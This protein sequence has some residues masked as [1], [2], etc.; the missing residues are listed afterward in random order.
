MSAPSARR[1]HDELLV[2]LGR[3][4]RAEHSAVT[5]F[6]R[7]WREDLF[8]PLGHATIE[9][10]GTEGL[11]L[12]VAKTR[13][14]LRL[15]RALDELPATREALDA[16]HLD[17]TK[18]RT[19]TAVATPRTEARWVA[20]AAAATSRELEAKVRDARLRN[21]RERERQRRLRGQ[22]SMAL[23]AAATVSD[24]HDPIEMPVTN[25]I[26]MSPV[27]HARY[28]ALLERLRKQDRCR[29]RAELVLDGL[30]ALAAVD[31]PREPVAS[32]YHIVAYRCDRC[33]TNSVGD[34]PV[35]PASAAAMLCDAVQLSS[36]RSVPNRAV[37]PP[38]V[39]RA[40]LARD[41]HRCIS[42]GCG[43][44]H[45]LEVHHLEPRRKGGDNRPDNLRTLCSACHRFAH[46]RGAT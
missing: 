28:E 35:A 46:E 4:R 11:W 39:R 1:V 5:L 29:P 32:P 38:S 27:Q 18:A 36:E 14:F 9:L 45:F 21:R 41:G 31:G 12:S 22:E 3:L 2:A 43:A 34:R 8:R 33:N 23:P 7:V 19:L 13:Q 15:A 26:T 6:A 44:R 25:S 30:A 42:P 24:S 37:I 17:W 10:Y 16:G 40:I 20:V